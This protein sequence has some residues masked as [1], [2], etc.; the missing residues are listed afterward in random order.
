MSEPL[1]VVADFAASILLLHK[2]I[3][4][5]DATYIDASALDT[6]PW[7]FYMALN[8]MFQLYDMNLKDITE[9]TM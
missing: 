6:R 7:N 8:Y 2:F 3:I 1:R 4:D 5:C 9:K